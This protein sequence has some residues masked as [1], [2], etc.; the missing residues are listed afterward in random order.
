[1]CLPSPAEALGLKEEPSYPAMSEAKSGAR[2]EV[3]TRGLLVVM[4]D[5]DLLLLL[6]SSLPLP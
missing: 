1:M 2:S 4:V 3:Q 6:R 5:D